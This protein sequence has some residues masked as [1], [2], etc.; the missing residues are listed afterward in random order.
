[1]RRHL[2]VHPDPPLLQ[3]HG[4]P[5]RV[6]HDDVGLHRLV[7]HRQQPD[8]G[9]PP[10]GQGRRDLRERVAR[11]QH[12]GA[13]QVRGDVAVAEGEPRRPGPVGGELVGD[14]GALVPP[15]PALLLVHGAAEGVQD[16]VDVGAD[17]QAVQRDVVA[18]VGHHGDVGTAGPGRGGGRGQVLQQA[19]DEP[20]AAHP[21]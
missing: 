19:A 4:A 6:L 11:A 1:V 16:G 17:P 10:L 2:G 12:A 5:L 21:S 9:L 8:A 7:R 15:A 18:G 13:Y 20:G 14:G 3:V